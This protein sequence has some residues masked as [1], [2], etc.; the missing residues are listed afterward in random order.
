VVKYYLDRLASSPDALRGSFESYRA[1]DTS[2]AEN[3][4]RKKTRLTLPVLA[5]GGAKSIGEG[6]ANTMKLVADDV[7]SVVIPESGH[8]VAEEVPEKLLEALTPF[9][10][11]YRAPAC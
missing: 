4:R 8:W 3:E 11:P 10:A 5:V 1:I 2:I 9:L 6:V 7:Q